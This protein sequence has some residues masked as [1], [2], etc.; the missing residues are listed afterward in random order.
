[1]NISV[2]FWP[3]KFSNAKIKISAIVPAAF[4]FIYEIGVVKLRK[5]RIFTP[6]IKFKCIKMK[7]NEKVF[8][9]LCLY[10]QIFVFL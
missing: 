7:N 1:M 5:Y 10:V 8:M 3:D 2:L 6:A 4:R 9:I